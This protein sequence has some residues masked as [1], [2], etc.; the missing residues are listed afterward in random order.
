MNSSIWDQKGCSEVPS[1][2]LY[3]FFYGQFFYE[4][5]GVLPKESFFY[6]PYIYMISL[7]CGS[8]NDHHNHHCLLRKTENIKFSLEFTRMEKGCVC[9]SP[10]K[11]VHLSIKFGAS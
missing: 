3:H 8:S 4:N 2:D 10:V 6:T 9:V 1:M 7:L 5:Y 11:N